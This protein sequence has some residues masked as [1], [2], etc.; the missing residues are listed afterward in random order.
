[1]PDRSVVYADL[2]T[3]YRIS[4]YA[5]V[6]VANGPPTHVADTTANKPYRRAA[7]LKQFLHT[8]ELSIPRAAGAGWLV[9]RLGEQ[10]RPDLPLVYRDARF[11]V[12]RL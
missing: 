11:R 3:S 2:Q 1:V 5:P 7:Q 4:A 6:Y 9:L 8:G 10:L 12:Y